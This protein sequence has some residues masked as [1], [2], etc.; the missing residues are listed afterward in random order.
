MRMGM[1][2]RR[3]T[4]GVA[5]PPPLHCLDDE[6]DDQRTNEA[7]VKHLWSVVGMGRNVSRKGRRLEAHTSLVFPPCI[8]LH[9]TPSACMPQPHW[10]PHSLL[11]PLLPVQAP[12]PPANAP[13]TPRL[14]P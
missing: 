10:H 11:L 6:E 14:H 13:P 12:L 1:W 4:L 3:G 8:T 9:A 2:D 7:R 5:P